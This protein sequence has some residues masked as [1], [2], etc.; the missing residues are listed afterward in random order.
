VARKVTSATELIRALDKER[1]DRSI[2]TTLDGIDA[3]TGGGLRRGKMLEVVAR[4]AAGRFSVVL[5]AL[6]SATSI[7]EAAALVDLGD[8][9]DPQLAEANGVDLRRLLW[10]RPHTMKQAVMAAEMLIATG[11]QL[12]VLDAGLHPIRG[13]RRAPDAAWVRLARAAEGHGAA[14]LVS[15]PYP[16]TGTMSE[17]VIRASRGR[18]KWLGSGKA[19][20]LLAG[21]ESEFTLDRHRHLRPGAAVAQRL[22][23]V[24]SSPF[25]RQSST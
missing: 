10:V 15:S 20:R 3:L 5:S 8:N 18:A 22:I 23:S 9:F 19:P 14:M 13:R 6:V 21:F 12:V 2:P 16:L 17:G 1:R 11:F 25:T 7:G 24:D 4:R